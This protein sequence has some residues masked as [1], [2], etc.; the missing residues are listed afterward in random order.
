MT[1]SMLPWER[2]AG[3]SLGGHTLE[4]RPGVS[5]R[6]MEEGGTP[7]YI[8]VAGE[9][10]ERELR[11]LFGWLRDESDLRRSARISMASCA[12]ETGAMGSALE[13]IT[14]VTDS[15]F[16]SLNLALAYATWRASRTS[17][18]KVTIEHG[19]TKIE[20]DE[21]DTD[22]VAKIIRLLESDRP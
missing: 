5:F 7:I 18:P 9:D 15:G 11:S 22:E 17:T 13:A 19:G 3:N 6:R 14:L 2:C 16:Q 10:A 12:P 21:T 20:L 4:G 8:R 1:A